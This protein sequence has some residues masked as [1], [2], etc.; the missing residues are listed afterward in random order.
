MNLKGFINK[1]TD[2]LLNDNFRQSFLILVLS[3]LLAVISIFAAFAHFLK[4]PEPVFGIIMAVV[5]TSAVSVF[6]LCIFVNKY[7]FIWR[8]IFMALIV[9]YFG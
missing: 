4:D 7:A 5:F 1:A 8:R 3:A 6:L 9:V 2:G